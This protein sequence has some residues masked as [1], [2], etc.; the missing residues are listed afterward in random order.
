MEEAVSFLS[1][2][3]GAI[4]FCIALSLLFIFGSLE[5]EAIDALDEQVIYSTVYQR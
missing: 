3:C 5:Q 4:I 1:H 2:V